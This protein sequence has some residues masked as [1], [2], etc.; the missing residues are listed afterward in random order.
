MCECAKKVH[1]ESDRDWGEILTEYGVD[2]APDTA[3][4]AQ[5]PPILGGV[6][7]KEYLEQ[8]YSSA[9]SV[10]EDEYFKKL[11]LEKQD[12]RKEKQKLFDER[13]SLSRL[14]REQGRKDDLVEI[15]KR[16]IEETVRPEFDYIPNEISDSDADMIVHFTDVHAG[17]ETYSAFNTF[18]SSILEN[19]IKT[20]LDE[21]YMIQ[22][23]QHCQDCC[24]ILGGDLI[25]GLIHVNSRIEDK[26]NVMQQ[27][28]LVSTLIS[29][30]IFELSN[31]FQNVYVYST[32]GN[33]SRA[34]AN[35]ELHVKGEN[36]D[37]LI[38]FYLKASLQNLENVHVEENTLDEGI[39]T[40]TVRGHVVYGSHGDKDTIQSVV[41]NMTK[42][43]RK[44]GYPLPDMIYLG[45]RHSN[46]LTTVDDV[47]VIQGG[48]FDG[49]DS[50]SI[51]KRLVGT[52]EQMVTI[53]SER[54][55]IKALYDIQL[56]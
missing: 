36:F 50:Y 18:N 37:C 41:T 20:Y 39:C 12:I 40:F 56:D 51:D 49:M 30:F 19:R 2:F 4:K 47:K 17:V 32:P 34:N 27:I 55:R 21:I 44:A 24:V 54:K 14:V 45:H 8:K 11:R 13:A 25:D 23:E 22:K 16:V 48:C 35:K 6:F 29:N 52:P 7:I 31:E 1:K 3:R 9:G 26:E 33:H 28:M 5:Q 53:I 38:P 10:D 43:A 46:S 15:F 42:F